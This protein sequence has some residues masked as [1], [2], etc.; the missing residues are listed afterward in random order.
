MVG[1]APL[2]LFQPL[3]ESTYARIIFSSSS[4]LK[5]MW[6]LSFTAWYNCTLCLQLYK[7]R[8]LYVCCQSFLP[9]PTPSPP[10]RLD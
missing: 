8:M 7:L 3:L 1:V 9:R 5:Q 10:P 2:L 6:T 4:P